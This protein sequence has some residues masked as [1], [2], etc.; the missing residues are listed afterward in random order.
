[1]WEVEGWLSVSE[2]A[3]LLHRTIAQFPGPGSGHL[4][5]SPD[6]EDPVLSSDILGQLHLIHLHASAP[7]TDAHACT[8]L[9]VKNK[10]KSIRASYALD[11]CIG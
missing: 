8:Q 3:L 9:K 1:M 6:P 7:P 4:P 2:H 5:V 11:F 10:S